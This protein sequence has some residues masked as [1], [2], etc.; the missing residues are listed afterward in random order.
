MAAVNSISS[1][2]ICN[3]RISLLVGACFLIQ[4]QALEITVLVSTRMCPQNSSFVY[5]V[6]IRPTSPRMIRREPEDIKVLRRRDDGVRFSIVPK[7]WPRELALYKLARNR[8]RV[9]FI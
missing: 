8:K 2:N 1:V 6:C 9:V 7:L 3:D 4:A 5:I